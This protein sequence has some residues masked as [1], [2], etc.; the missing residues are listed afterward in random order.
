MT[1]NWNIFIDMENTNSKARL[2]NGDLVKV[3][4][5]WVI[6]VET[7]KDSRI[8]WVVMHVPD[9]DQNLLSF[10]QLLENDYSPHFEDDICVIEL[11]ICSY[12]SWKLRIKVFL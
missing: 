4:G 8:I 10:G 2:G 5:K 12:Q 9:L 1:S 11:G 6:E 3:K 7:K